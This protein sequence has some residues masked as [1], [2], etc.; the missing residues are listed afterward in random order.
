MW[1]NRPVV[2]EF[3]S[4]FYE[5][6]KILTHSRPIGFG[7]PLPLTLVEMEAYLRLYQIHPS[8]WVAFVR[9]MRVIDL[10]YL[11]LFDKAKPKPPR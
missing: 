7:G 4:T 3:A 1:R 5:A 2:E 11:E 6:F 8:E 9:L 10:T